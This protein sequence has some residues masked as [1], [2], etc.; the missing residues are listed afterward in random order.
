MLGNPGL[1]D[2]ARIFIVTIPLPQESKGKQ[3]LLVIRLRVACLGDLQ[4]IDPGR[5]V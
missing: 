1:S 4:L 3:R 5:D 2:G